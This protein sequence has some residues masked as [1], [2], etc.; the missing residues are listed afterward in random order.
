MGTMRGAVFLRYWAMISNN[1]A[2][3]AGEIS[4]DFEVEV[5]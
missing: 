1:S 3:S 4:L 2:F 5:Q